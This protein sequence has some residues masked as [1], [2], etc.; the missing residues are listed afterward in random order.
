MRGTVIKV[1]PISYSRNGGAFIRLEFR[2]ETGQW[3]K[4][5]LVPSFVNFARWK[6]FL[7]VGEDLDGILL[8]PGPIGK[9]EINADSYPRRHQTPVEGFW[10]LRDDG[11]MEWIVKLQET[12]CSLPELKPEPVQTKLL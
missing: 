1:H 4:T 8:K 2:L 10:K 9:P 3:A 7:T 6:P 11:C 12:P 5:D